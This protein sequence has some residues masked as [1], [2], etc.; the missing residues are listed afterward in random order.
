MLNNT[1]KPQYFAHVSISQ[2]GH[3][4]TAQLTVFDA[5]A[6]PTPTVQTWTGYP[7]QVKQRVGRALSRLYDAGVISHADPLL[8]ALAQVKK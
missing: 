2:C 7:K 8:A 1:L 5:S 3:L 6:G 4:W